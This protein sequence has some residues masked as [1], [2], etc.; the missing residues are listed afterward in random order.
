MDKIFKQL[1]DSNTSMLSPVGLPFIKEHCMQEV[2]NTPNIK[3][4]SFNAFINDSHFKEPR[5]VKL[6]DFVKNKKKKTELIR[7]DYRDIYTLYSGIV[8]IF[9]PIIAASVYKK[10]NPT[11]ILDP[12]AGWGGRMIAANALN[13]NYIGIDTNTNLIV[14]YTKM[15]SHLNSSLITM[16]WNDCLSMDYSTLNYDMV[17]TSPPYYNSELYSNMPR[18]T[19]EEWNEWY[20]SF[21]GKTYQ[22]LKSKGHYAICMNGKMYEIF[23]S[24]L[25]ECN[26]KI[27]LVKWTRKHAKKESPNTEYIYVWVKI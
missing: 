18:R 8:A 2:D 6:I 22:H 10:F 21:A 26:E 19:K 25:G 27:K 11:S 4:M 9:R 16:Y 24:V 15:I 7:H 3:G 12:C 14:P 1:N 23:K 17:F 5:F 13:M 20:K